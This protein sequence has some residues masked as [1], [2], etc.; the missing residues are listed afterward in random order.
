M[1]NVYQNYYSDM[2]RQYNKIIELYYSE[3]IDSQLLVIIAGILTIEKCNRIILWRFFEYIAIVIM[4]L[5]YKFFRIPII[6]YSIGIY[7]IKIEYILQYCKINYLKCKKHILL[8]DN[9][10][11]K[12]LI[13]IIYLSNKFITIEDCLRNQF[14]YD[15]WHNLSKEQIK[16][17]ALYYSRNVEFKGD[18]NYYT[19]LYSLYM[20]QAY[21]T[22]P[23]IA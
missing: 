13:R 9:L 23:E 15:N 6:N 22:K 4:F 19:I 18:L 8:K 10:S 14:S 5:R 2:K 3:N 21:L 17:V 11:V 7:Q 20:G 1:N 16:D 12:E